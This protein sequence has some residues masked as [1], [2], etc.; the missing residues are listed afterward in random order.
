M[1]LPDTASHS[2]I[3]RLWIERT[4]EEAGGTRW[5]G[6]IF[7]VPSGAGRTFD[8]LDVIVDFIG[9]YL[10]DPGGPG[11]PGEGPDLDRP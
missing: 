7:H 3:V 4:P 1:D 9:L 5:R 6:R 11:P 10:V 2:F 8:T